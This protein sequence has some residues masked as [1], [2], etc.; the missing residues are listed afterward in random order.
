MGDVFRTSMSWGAVVIIEQVLSEKGGALVTVPPEA[1]AI[2]VAQI[3]ASKRIGLVI[4]SSPGGRLLGVISERD[5]VRIVAEDVARL[6]TLSAGDMMSPKVI[7]CAPSD[8]VRT[9]MSS[10]HERGFRHMPVVQSGHV[11]GLVS[12]RDLLKHLV[13]EADLHQKAAAWSDLDFI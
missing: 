11:R 12:S 7:T 2:Q 9:V 13:A 5:I 1:T 10:M 3:L 4:V 6:T 8:D